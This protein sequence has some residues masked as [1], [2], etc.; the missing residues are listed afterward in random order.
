MAASFTH[1]PIVDVGLPQRLRDIAANLMSSSKIERQSVTDD[2][3]RALDATDARQLVDYLAR[4]TRDQ[5]AIQK[6]TVQSILRIADFHQSVTDAVISGLKR[7]P[8]KE[9][10]PATVLLFRNRDEAMYRPLFEDWRQGD[11]PRTVRTAIEQ[12]MGR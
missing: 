3:L 6:F 1:K 5:P 9:L 4:S 10:T 2:V 11:T 8:V 7:V 12:V